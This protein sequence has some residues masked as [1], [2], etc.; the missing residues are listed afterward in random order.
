[1]GVQEWLR[2]QFLNACKRAF[3]LLQRVW[4]TQLNYS[5]IKVSFFCFWFVL[6]G[7]KASSTSSDFHLVLCDGFNKWNKAWEYEV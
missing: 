4:P 6:R 7:G 2:I 1:M 3:A 5:Y